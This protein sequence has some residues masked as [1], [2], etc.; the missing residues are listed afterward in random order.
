MAIP[1]P[2]SAICCLDGSVADSLVQV[3]GT[4]DG[5]PRDVVTEWHDLS[6]NG[7][8]FNMVTAAT[9]EIHVDA[10][11]VSN[12]T[13][14]TPDYMECSQPLLPDSGDWTWTLRFQSHSAGVDD[15]LYSQY[16]AAGAG[17]LALRSRAGV[18]QIDLF[19]AG[20]DYGGSTSFGPGDRGVPHTLTFLRTASDQRYTMRLNGVEVFSAGIRTNTPLQT[21]SRLFPQGQ[22]SLARMGV[23]SEALSG[24]DLAKIEQWAEFGLPDGPVLSSPHLAN[25]L[26]PSQLLSSPHLL[27]SFP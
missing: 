2:G 22:W 18:G 3:P 23:W 25:H 14:N 20:N 16:Q 11:W 17:R 1:F 13:I 6:A 27:G 19:I 21:V 15:W 10:G 7:F 9:N 4:V 5:V 24:A 8:V 12:Q 26:D